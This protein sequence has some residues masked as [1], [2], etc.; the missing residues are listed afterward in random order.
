MSR[1]DAGDML[2]RASAE[3]QR[4]ISS[5]Y[6]RTAVVGLG[7]GMAGVLATLRVSRSPLLSSFVG[8]IVGLTGASLDAA[9]RAPQALLG[10]ASVAGPSEIAD[11][12]ICPTVNEFAPCR[13]DPC[14]RE[15]LRS[16]V[17]SEL[18]VACMDACRARAAAT[19]AADDVAPWRQQHL[20][21]RTEEEAAARG[22]PPPAEMDEEAP[23]ALGSPSPSAQ[24][25][26]RKP[27]RENG[28]QP[29]AAA[30]GTSWDA[31]RRR[32]QERLPAGSP[33]AAAA[34][35]TDADPYG[36]PPHAPHDDRHDGPRDAPRNEPPTQ[37]RKK[38]ACM[39]PRC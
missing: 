35:S 26:E 14:C 21:P 2:S 3:E 24:H 16:G 23:A 10:V 30:A 4:V 31:V 38:N 34:N 20:L 27:P 8:W 39:P 1:K 13:S 9:N 22:E 7:A 19:R 36:D 12:I 15:L 37:R 17:Q 29:A 33:P 6:N 28:W 11:K 5:A 25:E 18:L 32:H